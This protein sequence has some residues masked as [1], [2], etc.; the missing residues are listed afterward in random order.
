M[1]LVSSNVSFV[2]HPPRGMIKTTTTTVADI[3]PSSVMKRVEKLSDKDIAM[4]RLQQTREDLCKAIKSQPLPATAELVKAE[5]D[6]NKAEVERIQGAINAYRREQAARE[7]REKREKLEKMLREL[8]ADE[9]K[10]LGESAKKE[11]LPL[12]HVRLPTGEIMITM[13]PPQRGKK[14]TPIAE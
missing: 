7:L 13:D 4:R 3:L 8:E 1:S 9:A 11:P 5:I 10:L 12:N 2:P 14:E 6:S